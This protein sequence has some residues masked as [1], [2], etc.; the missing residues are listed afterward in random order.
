MVPTTSSLTLALEATSTAPSSLDVP[1]DALERL[2]LHVPLEGR[3]Q[4]RVLPNTSSASSPP[5]SS[6]KR[7]VFLFPHQRLI[8]IFNPRH[9]LPIRLIH[10]FSALSLTPFST[11]TNIRIPQCIRTLD[12]PIPIMP[13]LLDPLIRISTKPARRTLP[14]PLALPSSTSPAL[15]VAKLNGSETD[16][17]LGAAYIFNNGTYDLSVPD[18]TEGT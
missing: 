11:V 4:R 15:T 12:I 7:R 10:P 18:G 8:P 2:N 3:Q 16:G 6:R 1:R 13:P 9:Q 17:G 5:P 14:R